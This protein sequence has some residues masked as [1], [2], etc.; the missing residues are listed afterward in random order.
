MRQFSFKDTDWFEP[1]ALGMESRLIVDS[2]IAVSSSKDITSGSRMAR[3]NV[4]AT[5][6]SIST[7]TTKVTAFNATMNI[8]NNVTTLNTSYVRH[9]G[10]IAAI[11]DTNPWFQVD[12]RTNVT[13]TALL[14]QGLDSGVAWVTKYFLAS[15]YES[16]VL[17]N[18]T[19]DEKVKVRDWS[20]A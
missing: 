11:N 12:F 3:L 14:L 9:G 18:Y 8:T 1:T 7:T 16:G 2:Q 10:W 5:I 13:V 17:Q 20:T 4:K 19:V 6:L 15:G